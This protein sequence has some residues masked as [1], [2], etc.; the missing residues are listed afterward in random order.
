MNRNPLFLAVMVLLPVVAA[1]CPAA[2]LSE[3]EADWLIQLESRSGINRVRGGRSAIAAKEDAA[4]AVDGIKDGEWGFH[5]ASENKPW[6]HVDLTCDQELARVVVYNRCKTAP[7]TARVMLL[8][9]ADGKK[10]REVYRHNGKPFYGFTDKKPLQIPVMGERARFVRLQLPHAGYL[11]LDEVEVYGVKD[12]KKNLALGKPADQS[13]TSEWSTG[14]RAVL[15][16]AGPKSYPIAETL[17][18]G[19]RLAEDLRGKGVNVGP[20]LAELD[21]VAAEHKALPAQAA[22]G[23][24]RELYF[25]ARRAIRR[26][27]LANPLLDFDKIL[28]TKRAPTQYSHMS[29]Q[30]YGWWS[31]PGGGIYVLEGLKTGKPKLR[32]LTKGFEVGSFLRPDLS[33]DAKKILFA[34]CKYYRHVAGIG[35]KVDKS[36]LPEDALYHVYEMNVDGTGVRRVT[37]GKYDDFDPRYLPS[38]EIVFLSTRRGQFFQCGRSSAMSTLD[39]DLPDSYVRC[40]GGNSR[41]VAVYTL[42]VM[43]ANGKNLRAISAFENFEWTPSVSADGRIFY[44]RW[45]YVDRHNNAFMSLWSTHPDGTNPQGV[46]GNFTRKPH[47]IFEAR[48]IPNSN[49]IIFTASAHHAITAGSLVL[50]DPDVAQDGPAPLTRLTPEVCFPE[51]EGWPKTYYANPYPLSEKYYFTA[52]SPN[53]IHSEGGRNPLNSLGVYLYDVFGNLELIHRDPNLGTTYPIPLRPRRK[54]PAASELVRRENEQTPEGKEGR[55]MLVNVYEGLRDVKAGAVKRLRIVGVPAKVQPQMNSPS[56]GVTSEDPGKCVLGTVPIEPDGSAYFR[57]PAGVNVF[58]QALD[59]HGRAVQTMRTITYVQPGQTLSC[60]GCHEPRTNAPPAKR[61]LAMRRPPSKITVG[62]AGSW[63]L[64]F[65]TLVQPVLDKH[66]VRCHKPGG[67]KPKAVAKL[68]L[69]GK[70]SYK[71]LL[72]YGGL[73]GLV[74]SRYGAGRSAVQD[75]IALKS[76]LPGMFLGDKP[77][78]KVRL[79]ADALDRIVTWLDVYAQRLGSFSSE[80]ERH[81]LDLRKAWAH[82]LVEPRHPEP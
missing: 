2:E 40:G 15:L 68:D 45:D 51:M 27:V 24:Q 70:E 1:V 20:S 52:W 18:R 58:F 14:K 28:I 46:Y 65:D 80:Q 8:L 48:S 12:P 44:A 73:R 31:R 56:I 49:K 63:P 23:K 19:R 81:L 41:P 26:L 55:V 54:P 21:K 77:H 38:G 5:T 61:P 50:L 71:A 13:S 69:T 37:R 62:P 35:N 11:H 16:P 76:R 22:P 42:H 53:P 72:A 79:D 34:Y 67:E 6:W 3:V 82:M 60:I 29:D 75:C 78:N 17:D 9:S 74:G 66:C 32:C 4:G 25:R 47:C 33:Y 30:Y 43:D 59:A 7:R 10:W 64:R 36:K 57:M 39:G